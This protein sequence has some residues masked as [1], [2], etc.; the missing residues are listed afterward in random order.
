VAT[1]PKVT[2]IVGDGLAHV[3][4]STNKYDV[5]IVDSSDPVGP[6]ESLFGPQFV[7]ALNNALRSGGVVAT[8]CESMWLHAKIIQQCLIAASMAGFNQARYA[9]ASVPTYPCGTIGFMILAKQLDNGDDARPVSTASRPCD[10]DN[11]QYYS[12]QAHAA[13]FVLPKFVEKQIYPQQ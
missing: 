9:W 2:V 6:A 5:I 10:I 11:L 12:D 3:N 1:H 4:N 7:V 8:Q 13:A